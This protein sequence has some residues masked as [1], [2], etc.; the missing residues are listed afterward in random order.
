MKKSIV[1]LILIF[2]CIGFGRSAFATPSTHIWAPSTDIQGYGIFHLTADVYLPVQ[3]ND[4]LAGGTDATGWDRP[5]PVTNLGLTVGVL[6]FEKLQMEIGFDHITGYSFYDRGDLDNSPMYFN[7]KIGIPEGAFGKYSPAFAVGGYMFGTED[8]GEARAGHTAEPGTDFN[9]L[10][11]KL[12]KTI[13]PLG[14]F[15]AGYYIGNKKL[16]VDENGKEEEDG[17]LLC[18]ER[19]MSEISENLWLAVEYVDGENSLGALSYG[20]AWKFAPNASVLFAYI[21]Q[22]N[23]EL[24]FVEDWFSVQVDIDW[25]IFGKK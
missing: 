12:G 18:W 14:R 6:P 9:V 11:A 4:E 8:N 17:V 22:N 20:F 10:Y 3:G 25:N 16:L 5:D 2:L 23:D 15:S 24:A 7:A 19:T 21:D 13:G 1:A